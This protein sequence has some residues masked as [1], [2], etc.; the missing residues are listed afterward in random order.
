MTPSELAKEV[1]ALEKKYPHLTVR[2]DYDGA[3]N[4]IVEPAEEEPLWPTCDQVLADWYGCVAADIAEWCF[5]Q[6][7]KAAG[8]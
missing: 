7:I 8:V 5:E 1:D 3:G 6:N 2:R 4:L